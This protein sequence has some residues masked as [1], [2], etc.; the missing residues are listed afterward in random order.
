MHCNYDK[1]T[2][3]SLTKKLGYFRTKYPEQDNKQ[4]EKKNVI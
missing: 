3:S 1:T 2:S 4:R